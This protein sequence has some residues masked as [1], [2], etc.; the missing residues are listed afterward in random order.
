MAISS[1][2]RD[3]ESQGVVQGFAPKRLANVADGQTITFAR[4]AVFMNEAEGSFNFNGEGGY[5]LQS[6]IILVADDEG[7]ALTPQGA[8]AR[9]LVRGDFTIT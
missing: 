5:F 4:G 2:V 1:I 7:T 9:F 6:N 3:P 8:A